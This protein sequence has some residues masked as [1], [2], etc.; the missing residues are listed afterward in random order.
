M[1][2][3]GLQLAPVGGTATA[4][5]VNMSVGG[6]MSAQS[7]SSVQAQQK[8]KAQS[9][10]TFQEEQA[11]PQI[12]GL[13]AHIKAF[14]VQAYQAKRGVEIK[15]LEAL[16]ARRGEY[17]AEKLSKIKDAGQPAIFMML[18]A[19]KMRQAEALM[20]D[21]LIGAGTEKPWTLEPEPVPDVP[22]LVAAQIKAA[23]TEELQGFILA[24]VQPS[25]N[26]VRERIL[27]AKDMALNALREWAREQCARM[28]DKMETQLDE[29]GFNEALDQFITDLTTFKT[30][31][32]AGPIV[33]KKVKLQ[34]V[35]GNPVPVV[36]PYACLEWERVSPFDMYPAPWARSV[37]D[38][39]T[40]RKHKLTRDH[41]NEMMGVDGFSDDAIRQ[42]LELY[43][44]GGL[45]DWLTVDSEVAR[46]E[47]KDTIEATITSGL[48]DA[49][50]YWGSVSG[51][52]LRE[53]GMTPKQVPDESKEYQVEA[54]MVGPYVIKS[55]LNA[56]PLA[57]R[58]FYAA[59]YE[60]IPGS[61]WGNSVYDLMSDCQDMCNA[62][63]RSLAANLG[64]ASGPQV[65]VNVSRLP[66]GSVIS[67]LYPW[68]IWQV[69]EDQMGN[70][71]PPI[72]FFQPQSNAAELMGVYEKYS[73]LADEYTGI[74]R[75]MSGTEGTPGAGRTASG[76]SMMIGNASKVIKQVV[77]CVDNNV[78]EPLIERLY[79]YNMRYA[80]DPDL[81]GA[82]NVRARGAMSLTTKDA[83]QVRRNEF[84][85]ATNN[86][87]D[88]AI[89]GL[90]GRAELLRA[91]AIT[92]DMN[93]DKIVPPVAMLKAKQAALE[94]Q[95]M[96]E[97][98]GAQGGSP[99]SPGSPG[100]ASSGGPSPN[101]QPLMNGAPQTDTFQPTQPAP[102]AQPA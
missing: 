99:G 3:T 39:P 28:E 80:A 90:P 24:G 55:V 45:H 14:W 16:Y 82:V 87:T 7:L 42:V 32:I 56:D 74:P 96:A 69:E 22:P 12:I 84:L 35:P 88:M 9:E 94:Q 11:Q 21:V 51:K 13:A 63:A 15:M 52:M 72:T 54:W 60:M 43:G 10:Q 36:K 77:G 29:G 20:R 100:A 38:G 68:K 40:I 67:S 47:G 49:L 78:I 48:I 5:P 95:Q 17:T 65:V 79:Y 27:A 2:G 91:T 6:M 8:A 101:G 61:V 31:F 37:G 85:A 34:W 64:I 93:P 25:T 4:P 30:A 81:K 57:R 102:A 98:A 86:P 59:S 19:T 70:V 62:A 71:A 83:A 73:M 33:R 76:L 53:W 44:T 75:Y 89:L 97:A 58:P 23:L 18:S 50:Q 66:T 46:A 1:L 41:L 26:E 92:L